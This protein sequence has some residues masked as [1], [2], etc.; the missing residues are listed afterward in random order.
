MS[1][2]LH[3]SARMRVALLALCA[4]AITAV[5]Y[6]Q[7]DASLIARYMW[8]IGWGF[9]AVVAIHG[10]VI[11][12]DAVA[13]RALLSDRRGNLLLYVWSRWVREA[14]N[15]L[16]PVAQVGGE[17]VA[18]RLMVLR[19]VAPRKAIGGI[20][21]DKICEAFSQAPFALLG[22]AVFTTITTAVEPTN[23]I[24]LSIALGV[25]LVL[26]VIA[27]QYAGR[28][29]LADKALSAASRLAGEQTSDSANPITLN[30]LCQWPRVTASIALHLLAWTIGAF[31]LWIALL[32]MGQPVPF[33]HA[34]AL[35]S[36][37]Q[38]A[39][40]LGFLVP[41]GISVQEGSFLALGAVLG[42]SPEAALALSL[43]KRARQLVLGIPALASWQ[44]AEASTLGTPRGLQPNQEYEPPSSD[45]NS[46]VRRFARA[47]VRPFAHSGLTPN[48]I[49]ALRIATGAAACAV[50]ALPVANGTFIA[51]G[52]WFLSTLLDRCD[53]EFARLTQRCSTWGHS[54]DY[55]GDNILNALIFLAI[56][57]HLSA[58]A[59]TTP[60]ALGLIA[61]TGVFA[62]SI[63]AEQL[64]LQI[65]QKTVPSQFGL[66][67][68]DI[69][70]AVAALIAVGFLEP[71]LIG[72]AIG[73]PLAACIIGYRLLRR[74]SATAG[75]EMNVRLGNV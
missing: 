6:A 8:A 50:L 40:S 52:L 22:I 74:S 14:T 10:I 24:A 26:G 18:T 29:S 27:L 15:L 21:V 41:A 28:L 13:W 44:L 35:E 42:I 4:L 59:G 12:V 2:S 63:L 16:L 62:A 34:F 19:G 51:A 7:N 36:L 17:I 56:G 61:A 67:F 57:I 45:S 71:L 70:F 64:E 54:F 31:E 66:D 68:D 38:I 39:L 48:H 72:A 55:W 69:V 43:I 49:T 23:V 75:V 5:L 53:G 47:C 3:L 60:V 33:G 65:A 30:A 32:C 1:L 9:L 46:Y 37:S 25:A 58:G 11:T 20:V 73:G